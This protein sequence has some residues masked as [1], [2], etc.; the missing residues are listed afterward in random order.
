[1]EIVFAPWRLEYILADKGS[2]ACIF[3]RAFQE[4][5]SPDNLVLYRD[6]RVAVLL[7][8]YP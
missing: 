3:C 8:K 7:N 1:M 6:D 5:P 2:E 4:E